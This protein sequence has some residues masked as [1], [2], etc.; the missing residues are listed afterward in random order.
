MRSLAFDFRGDPQINSIP[1]QYMFGPAFLVNPV[2][3]RMYSFN[4]NTSSQKTRKVYLPEPATWYDFWTGQV[5]KGGMTIDAPAPIE[6][7]PLYIKAGS[8]VPMGPWLQYATEKPADPLEIRIYPGADGTFLLYEDE[9]DTY[10]YEEGVFSTIPFTWNDA[11]H[12]LIIGKRTG[13]FPG[14]KTERSINLVVVN[15]NNGIGSGIVQ[16][17]DKTI[18]YKGQEIK[19]NL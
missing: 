11:K 14:M 16:N 19:I 9:N 1:D 4:G 15:K 7:I 6:T 8:I 13:S 17:P 2:T 5:F 18:Q 12:Q 3:E 10:N